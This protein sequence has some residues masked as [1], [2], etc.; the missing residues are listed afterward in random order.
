MNR[1]KNSTNYFISFINIEKNNTNLTE[2]ITCIIDQ[3]NDILQQS[4]LECFV[5][6]QM[7]ET[8]EFDN[9]YLLP[10][11]MSLRTEYY[12][13]IP[14][15]IIIKKAIRAGDEPDPEPSFSRYSKVSFGLILA[16]ILIL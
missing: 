16:L 15:Q 6:S 7:N 5:Y 8:I 12:S 11:Y 3:Y 9:L 1:Y 4:E 13:Q 2:G 10:Y 14:F